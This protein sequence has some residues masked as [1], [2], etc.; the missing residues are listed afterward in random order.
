VARSDYSVRIVCIQDLV[1]VGEE[2]HLYRSRLLAPNRARD[3]HEPP[4]GADGHSGYAG[5]SAP[6]VQIAHELT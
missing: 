2:S 6:R 4:L 1:D 5:N 3:P